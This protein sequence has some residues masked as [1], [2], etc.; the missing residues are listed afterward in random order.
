MKKKNLHFRFFIL[1]FLLTF[2]IVTAAGFLLLMSFLHP[3]P[4]QETVSDIPKAR[5][6][7]DESFTVLAVGYT[8]QEPQN[9][10]F[11]LF[12][13]DAPTWTLRVA[14]L[15]PETVID[16]R[17]GR[18]TVAET[19]TYAG[20][21]GLKERLAEVLQI[22]VGRVIRMEESGFASLIDRAG[23]VRLTLTESV[24]H[25]DENGV[26]DFLLGAGERLLTGEKLCGV[27]RYGNRLS[28][29]AEAFGSALRQI[30]A[31]GESDAEALFSLVCDL[32]DSDLS[33]MDF[34]A[35]RSVLTDCLTDP[36]VLQVIDDLAQDRRAFGA[37]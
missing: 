3:R 16:T 30:A 28:L 34:A 21:S 23:A 18:E 11:F 24:E 31:G 29:S 6:D 10:V 35:R 37:Q 14:A 9:A 2:G 1:S 12:R 22:P 4:V 33:V 26:T 13:L 20:A 17:S 8:R 19:L 5:R 36:P 7:A 15:D 32:S 27:I 25:I